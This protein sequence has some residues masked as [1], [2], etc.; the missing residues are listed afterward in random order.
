MRR[1]DITMRRNDLDLS[2]AAPNDLK[3][4]MQLL[5]GNIG[6]PGCTWNDE[7]PTEEFI[8]DDINAQSL[9]VLT[10]NG[11]I[12][13]VCALLEVEEFDRLPW[14]VTNACDLAR[15]G[16]RKDL[17]RKGIGKI[18]LAKMIET[19]KA[20]YGGIRLLVAKTNQAALGLYEGFGFTRCG[21]AYLYDVDW[22]LYELGFSLNDA[23]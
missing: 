15:F 14:N 10:D 17:H 13:A 9:Y 20:K 6:T 23:Q 18:L 3:E 1:N 2:L 22:W 11:R 5:R 16:V 21:E 19:A 7:Y 4:V 12:A 8:E